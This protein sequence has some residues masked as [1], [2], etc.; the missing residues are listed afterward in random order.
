MSHQPRTV[1]KR[2]P[3]I[4]DIHCHAETSPRLKREEMRSERSEEDRQKRSKSVD[5]HCRAERAHG[6]RR[7]SEDTKI[8]RKIRM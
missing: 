7:R 8:R 2:L 1:V 6:L 4:R 3:D 5:V